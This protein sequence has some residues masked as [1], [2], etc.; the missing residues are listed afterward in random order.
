MK[1]AM[2]LDGRITRPPGEGQWLTGTEARA[3]VQILRGEVDAI[4][5]SGAT[6]RNDNPRLD[7]RGPRSEK[8]QPARLVYTN[9]AQAGLEKGAHLLTANEGGE[10]QFLSGGFHANFKSLVDQGLQTIL[11][12]AG[13]NLIG[14]LLD[15]GLVDE[16]I[17]YHAP[18]VTGGDRMAVGGIGITDLEKRPRL[19]NVTYQQFGPD[20]RVRGLVARTASL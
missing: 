12:E 15:E 4:L 19:K 17:S 8:R 10:T 9:Q 11:V 18:I 5:T 13:G 6:A 1:T 20:I 7:Y 3:D 14:Q 16:W 2:S